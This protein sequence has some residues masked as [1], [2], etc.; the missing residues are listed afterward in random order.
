MIRA[1]FRALFR[2][3][4]EPTLGEC[5]IRLS[6]LDNNESVST[7][8]RLLEEKGCVVIRDYFN[9]EML[10][11]IVRDIDRFITK[12]SEMAQ[13]RF[14]YK[15]AR[16]GKALV[17]QRSRE[18]WNKHSQAWQGVDY[19]MYDIFNPERSASLFSEEA[20]SN[21]T[22]V[23]R[24]VESLLTRELT[25]NR[26]MRS[27]TNLYVYRGIESPRPLHVD[28]PFIQT[29]VFISLEDADIK[30]GLYCYVKGSHRWKTLFR[31]TQMVNSLYGSDLGDDIYD[32]TLIDVSRAIPIRTR[33]GDVIITR[34]EGI[35]G[36]LPS[37]P[38]G[39]KTVLVASYQPY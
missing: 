26:L 27:W 31:F 8:A 7:I 14:D 35:H 22:S 2:N 5:E 33:A 37:T 23:I 6:D 36:D 10:E 9:H 34:Q 32:A 12:S 21:M 11:S 1:W 38:E 39:R 20:K 3:R 29:K 19:G 17:T 24:E 15:D 30:D 28:T 16:E 18:F 13:D 4:H 25:A